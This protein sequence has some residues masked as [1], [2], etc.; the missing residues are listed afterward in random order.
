MDEFPT[1]STTE[2]SITSQTTITHVPS[3]PVEA[4]TLKQHTWL[5]YFYGFGDIVLV[6]LPF[7]FIL[8]GV[9]VITLNG[10]AT[11][12]SSFGPKVEKAMD[13]GPTIFP[14]V[15]AAISGRSMK[16]IARYLAERGTRIGTLELLMA[17][18][19]VWGTVES[20]LLMQ[21][22]TIVGA[23]LLFLWALSPLGGQAS[24]R[25]MS[26]DYA[27]TFAPVKLR[28]MTT[29]PGGTMW[30]LSST[31][32]DSGKFADAG[33]LF[34]AALLAPLSTKLGPEDPWGN[35]KIPN[36]ASLVGLKP[37]SSGW[38]DVPLS[39]SEPESYS[40]LVGL[41]IVGLPDN[42]SSTF[43]MED[44]YL[45]VDCKPF[46]QHPYPGED[47]AT[48]YLQTNYT[49]LEEIAPGQVW[50]NKTE[51]DPFQMTADG[52]IRTSF[53]LDTTRSFPW[54]FL[55]DPKDH[56]TFIGRLDG[57]VGHYNTSMASE[58]ELNT[59]R[60][61]LY[62]SQY[63]IGA[64]SDALGLNIATCSLSQHH[65]EALIHCNGSRCTNTKLRT[66][67][68]DTRPTTLTGLE[69][70]TIMTGFA[71]HFPAAVTFNTGSSPTEIF[72][73]NTSSFPFVQ[74]VG[75][76]TTASAFADLY[77]LSPEL[78]S[79]RLSLVINTYY[80][81]STQP[82]GY[83]GGLSGN[84]SAYGPDT[85]PNTDLNVYLPSNLSATNHTF[86]DWYQAFEA[87]IQEINSPFIG[88]TTTAST[89][90]KKEIFICNYAWLALL[91]TASSAILLTGSF[92]LILKRRTLGPEMFGFVSSMT[93]ENPYVKI[94]AGGSMLDAMERARL[95][96]DVSVCL[97]DV[98]GHEQVGHIALA[99]GVPIRKLERGRLY[100]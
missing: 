21:R 22:F 53:F 97:G 16:M 88:A 84:L 67:T 61:L 14:I 51:R 86:M 13:L 83:F 80:Q 76:L 74:Q 30:G 28:Y 81:L 20:Q 3:W 8:L 41:P 50:F 31:Y 52:S 29:G 69:H 46:T 15:F 79:K 25:L 40:S 57:F 75:H 66:S 9:A 65:V 54:G 37:N 47:N 78:F 82:T 32:V 23:N 60:D 96:K 1:P 87:N 99:A 34:T 43:T 38:I 26:R 10:K 49:R 85:L 19:S 94:P 93:Y 100:C 11:Q 44:T 71:Q 24:L 73:S 4:R 48:N 6:L 58:T 33:A 63:A 27:E 36:L 18:Q 56:D 7:Y 2:K 62:V 45:S 17:S 91:I 42:G 90:Y 95:L 77:K 5:S 12:G 92:A 98:D 35:V 68:T 59:K 64:D 55:E 70:G 72:M 89:S 39:F